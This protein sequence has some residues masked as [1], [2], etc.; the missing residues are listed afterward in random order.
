MSVR[1]LSILITILFFSIYSDQSWSYEPKSDVSNLSQYPYDKALFCS[2]VK[3]SSDRLSDFLNTRGLLFDDE[4]GNYI[5]EFSH[6]EED[7]II[8]HLNIFRYWKETN[9]ASG[10]IIE[11][12]RNKIMAKDDWGNWWKG[13]FHTF[14][15]D[16]MTLKIDSKP[17][18]NKTCE[19]MSATEFNDKWIEHVA[20]GKAIKEEELNIQRNKNLF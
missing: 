15:I 19:P 4:N 12:N 16:R 17:Y 20:I 14:I 10:F 3:E 8:P 11:W 7:K 18:R 5:Q 6:T 9:D 13:R 2:L 1:K